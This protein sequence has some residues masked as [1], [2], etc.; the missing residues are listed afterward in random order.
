MKWQTI[1]MVQF[2]LIKRCAR[3]SGRRKHEGLLDA[4]D[5]SQPSQRPRNIVG[6]PTADTG[7]DAATAAP[8]AAAAAPVVVIT[9]VIVIIICVVIKTIIT[10]TCG[11]GSGMEAG[12]IIRRRKGKKTSNSIDSIF[13]AIV[14][15][16]GEIR[17]E[18]EHGH[19]H[20]GI[21]GLG[22][23]RVKRAN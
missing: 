9:V 1:S 11:S 15:A 3:A 2:H 6:G 20:V 22:G 13:V 14:A 10:T 7:S 5:T 12:R 18:L 8:I 17:H 16:C 23:D 19:A 4:R 21:L